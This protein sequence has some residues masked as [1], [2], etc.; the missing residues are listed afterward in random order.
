MV[1]EKFSLRDASDVARIDEALSLAARAWGQTAPNPM[2]GAVIYNGDEKVGEGFHARF[3]DA[4][5]ETIALEKA[6]QRANGATLY[7]TLEPCAHHGKTPPCTDAIVAAGI[8]RVVAAVRDPKPAAAGG[9]DRLRHAGIAVDFGVRETEARELNSAFFN[10]AQSDRPWVTLKLALS[11]DGAMSGAQRGAGWLTSEESRAVVQRMRAGSDAIAV[12]VQTALA[13]DPQLTAR[14]DPPPRIPPT[15][16]VFDRSARLS[17]QSALARTARKIPTIL[18]TATGTRLPADLEQCGVDV[19]PAHD[20]GEA[21]RKLRERGVLSLLV[22]GGAGL[23]ASFLAGGY[24]DRLVIFR[25]PIILG[26]GALGAFSG[27]ASQEIVHAPRFRLLET[28][29]LGDDVMSV[30]SVRK[31]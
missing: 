22:E 3:G 15:R 13:D 27:I 4:H 18:V 24:V 20:V 25:A 10:A 5:A 6:G 21:L 2:V 26:E 29:A 17:S 23:A 28:R 31:P 30:Y 16:I 8:T 11:L 14:T 19:L 9:A 12:G 1:P 7:V